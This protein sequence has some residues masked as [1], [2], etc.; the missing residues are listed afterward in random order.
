ME[1]L[2]SIRSSYDPKVLYEYEPRIRRV[3]DT[4][5]DGTFSDDNSGAFSDLHRALLFGTNWQRPDYYFIVYEL[6]G[7]IDKKLQAIYDCKDRIAFGRKCLRNIAA[8][9]IF[10]SDRSV[11]EYADEIWHIEPVSP[12]AAKTLLTE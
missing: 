12:K 1:T 6:L 8:A 10:S 5:I 11:K 2:N 7:Y 4:L 9:G 3:L